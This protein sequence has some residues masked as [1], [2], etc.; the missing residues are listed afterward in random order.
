MRRWNAVLL[1][2]ALALVGA[3]CGGD[4]D[5]DAQT[6]TTEAGDDGDDDDDGASGAISS[7][8]DAEPAVVQIVAEGSFVEPGDVIEEA[9]EVTGVGSGS[10]AI[11][12]PEGIVV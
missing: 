7:M 2:T 9:F 8:G 11:I 6:P 1:V 4:D 3:E 12:D 10:G 5:D